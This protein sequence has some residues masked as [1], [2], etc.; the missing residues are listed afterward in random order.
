MALGKNHTRLADT[1]G[2]RE[3]FNL[4]EE[5]PQARCSRSKRLE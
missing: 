1:E 5:I 3:E 2:Q 4:I